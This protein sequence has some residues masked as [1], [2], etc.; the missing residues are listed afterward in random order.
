MEYCSEVRTK[1]TEGQY[2][3]HGP[4][5]V[6]ILSCLLYGLASLSDRTLLRLANVGNLRL[7]SANFER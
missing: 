1:T 5:Q 3:Q 6:R 7:P 2:L 4:E